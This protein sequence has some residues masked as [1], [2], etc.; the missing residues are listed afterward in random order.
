MFGPR[1]L[2]LTNID[3]YMYIAD[4]FLFQAHI[5]RLWKSFT[6]A[7]EKS[8]RQ[9]ATRSWAT[10]TDRAGR[11]PR[12]AGRPPVAARR[13]ELAPPTPPQ[14]PPPQQ[15]PPA[16]S[17]RWTTRRAPYCASSSSSVAPISTSSTRCSATSS[18]SS[19]RAG[20]TIHSMFWALYEYEYVVCR[21]R[22]TST[23]AEFFIL[24]NVAVAHC[25][26]VQRRR[27]ISRSPHTP[28]RASR[29]REAMNCLWSLAKLIA[30]C[31]THAMHIVYSNYSLLLI[32]I[33]I[34]YF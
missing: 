31:F 6:A 8:Q 16:H 26:L 29:V 20:S 5:S 4:I 3:Y 21:R 25:L 32:L 14:P 34:I 10:R 12:A 30:V 33:T 18:T 17:R 1:T 28:Q 27:R 22:R 7:R 2:L 15:P 19:V 9:R 13:P 11:L 24:V 23:C